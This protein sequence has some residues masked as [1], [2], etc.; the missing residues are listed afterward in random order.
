VPSRAELLASLQRSKAQ[1]LKQ[2]MAAVQLLP[3]QVAAWRQ[4]ADEGEPLAQHQSQIEA[5]GLFLAKLQEILEARWAELEGAA[6]LST[7]QAKAGELQFL[8]RRVYGA[9]RFYRE[10]LDQRLAANEPDRRFLA[11]AEEVA[12]SAYRTCI[13]RAEALGILTDKLKFEQPPLLHLFDWPSPVT[14]TRSR[15]ALIPNMPVHVIDLP[16]YETST[17][18]SLL[19]LHHEVAHGLVADLAIDPGSLILLMAGEVGLAQARSARWMLWAEEILADCM[20]ILLAGPPFVR[21]LMDE[22]MGL[23]P[24]DPDQGDSPHPPPYLRIPLACAFLSTLEARRPLPDGQ[25]VNGRVD[26]AYQDLAESYA[27]TWQALFSQVDQRPFLPYLGE[28]DQ[29]LTLLMDTPLQVIG[30]HI[31]RQLGSFTPADWHLIER[32]AEDHLAEG[33]ESGEEIKPRLVVSAARL[34]LDRLGTGGTEVATA[35]LH[36][37]ALATVEL[38]AEVGARALPPGQEQFL[39]Q[40]AQAFAQQS[41]PSAWMEWE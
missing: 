17:A 23:Q 32:V 13:A 34:A 28:M 38:Y 20:A 4:Y 26:Q 19:A 15:H 36:E 7:F 40:L 16:Y 27:A 1:S 12:W 25:A 8:I 22:L 9:W 29:V 10:R 3:E 18:W 35:A 39:D 31:L 41:Q 24:G 21:Q 14:Y 5:L 37:S 30:Q 11:V 6:D 2:W 33:E